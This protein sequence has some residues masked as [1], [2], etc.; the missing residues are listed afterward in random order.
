MLKEITPNATENPAGVSSE[1]VDFNQIRTPELY[2]GQQFRRAPI[3]NVP[4]P[5]LTENVTA[6]IPTILSPNLAYVGGTWKNNADN[7]ELLSEN[8]SVALKF[9][10]KSVNIVADGNA[11]LNVFLDGKLLSPEIYG[12]NNT[13]STISVTN[14]TIYRLVETS[15]YAVHELRFDVTGKFRIFTFTFG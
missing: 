13:N 2:F 7:F 12:E 10:A 15:E 5:I 1:P 14:S 3:A 11:S 9:Y 4:E 6:T 8:G